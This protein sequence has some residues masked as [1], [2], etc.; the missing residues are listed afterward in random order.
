MIEIWESE[1]THA[2]FD[3][4]L[5]LYDFACLNLESIC[6]SR[7]WS[8][9]INPFFTSLGTWWSQILLLVIF[10]VYKLWFDFKVSLQWFF[11]LFDSWFCVCYFLAYIPV[12]EFS[13]AAVMKKYAVKPDAETL[14]IVNTAAR[15]KSVSFFFFF[16]PFGSICLQTLFC[17]KEYSIYPICNLKLFNALKVL[18]H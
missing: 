11:L 5:I 7:S 16:F 8:C 1:V 2:S 14:D 9:Y 10:I 6:F 13:D 18:V 3:L 17:S 15:K 4:Q 12:S